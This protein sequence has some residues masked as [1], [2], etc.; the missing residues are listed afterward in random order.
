MLFPDSE[1][2]RLAVLPALVFFARI[3]DVSI[4]TMRIIYVSRGLKV[5]AS[6]CGF[7]EVLI[8]LMAITQIMQA[9]NNVIMYITYAGGFAAG[10]YVG[11][12]IESKSGRE[13][14]LAGCV[15]DATG[16]ADIAHLAGAPTRHI[17][18]LGWAKH[19]YCFRVGNVDVDRF[20]QYFVD[21]PGQYPEYMDVDWTFE[22]ALRQYR[23]TGTLLFP[24]GGG[25]Q[26]DLIKEGLASGEYCRQIGVHDSTAAL[27]MHAIRG[28]GV[29][30]MIT[31]FCEL[32]DLDVADITRAMTDGKRMAFH[33]TDYF[34]KRVPGFEKA[35]VV[36]LADDLGI[37][38]SRWIEG[39][40]DFT[41]EMKR[42]ETRFGDAIA[43]GVVQH[44]YR[45]SEA[46]GAWGCQ[47]FRDETYDIPY[48]CLIPKRIENLIMGAGRSA[49]QE[50]PML[51]R[52]MAVT[53]MVGQ[54]AGV[55][56]AVSAGTAPREVDVGMVQDELRRQGV[57]IG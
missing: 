9:L 11:I 40:L 18:E 6:V 16:D 45:K 48:R 52:V 32:P 28:L 31:G 51:L 27:Q 14:V 5:V 10:N 33:V 41:A 46:P 25:V 53:M 22:E 15:V 43:R 29:V 13:A 23:E 47:T 21:H 8:W 56:A 19:S 36:S 30:H 3:V 26:V 1:M 55:S 42:R 20:V 35:F 2:F 24:H 38:A 4:G 49:S 37:R 7:F 39:E 50:N 17:R 44:D 57:N 54:A 12:L 34:R